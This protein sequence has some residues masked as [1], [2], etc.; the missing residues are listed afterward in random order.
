M[1]TPASAVSQAPASPPPASG[2]GAAAGPDASTAESN[3]TSQAKTYKANGALCGLFS[4]FGVHAGKKITVE[5]SDGTGEEA[6]IQDVNDDIDYVDM[7]DPNDPGVG[8]GLAGLVNGAVSSNHSAFESD[9][10]YNPYGGPV[11]ESVHSGYDPYGSAAAGGPHGGGPTHAGVS[12]HH[13]G[14]NPYSSAAV[15]PPPPIY[16]DAVRA[17]VRGEDDYEDDI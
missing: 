8:A 1:A 12:S 3:K 9:V 5:A 6:E 4:C 2:Y 7:D 10:G 13:I 11:H 16:T 14:Y 15:C 17:V